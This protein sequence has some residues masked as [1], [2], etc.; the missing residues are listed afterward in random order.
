MQV[1]RRRLLEKTEKQDDIVTDNVNYELVNIFEGTVNLIPNETISKTKISTSFWQKCTENGY[2]S[3]KPTLSFCAIIPENS[4]IF[5]LVREG[6]LEGLI[7]HVQ[8]GHASLTDCDP[9]GRTLLNVRL[10]IVASF[11]TEY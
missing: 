10:E 7:R 5:T 2:F 3:L 6:D 11:I 8:Q 1:K 9:E 4:H